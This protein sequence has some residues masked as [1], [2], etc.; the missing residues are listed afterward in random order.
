MLNIGAFTFRYDHLQDRILLVGNFS[1]GQQ[2]I[3][4]WLTRKLVLRLLEGAQNLLEKTSEEIG[5]AP[6][7]HKA[8]LAQF[9]HEN[10][11]Q[12]LNAEREVEGIATID[13]HLLSRLD[14]SHQD[15]R[16]RM[17]FFSG[18]DQPSAFSVVTYAELHQ[19]LH[20]LHQGALTLDWGVSPVLF[21]S[22]T[23]PPT[24]Q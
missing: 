23:A 19:I 4:F 14:I 20:F 16:Y 9:H 2:R 22:D 21:Q 10:A 11:Q 15:G 5:E 17:L 12:N 6:Q 3:D 1:N 8:H 7:Q 18:S 24:I 13:G